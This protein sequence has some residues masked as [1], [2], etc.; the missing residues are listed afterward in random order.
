MALDLPS[1]SSADPT[2]EILVELK[3][4]GDN[5]QALDDH[6]ESLNKYTVKAQLDVEML[7][8]RSSN[9]NKHLQTMSQLSQSVDRVLQLVQRPAEQ[10]DTSSKYSA[11]EDAAQDRLIKLNQ[12]ILEKERRAAALD[13]DYKQMKERI[14]ERHSEFMQLQR[15]YHE[16]QAT[17]Q[18]QLKSTMGGV[19]VSSAALLDDAET[20]NASSK[21]QRITSMLREKYKLENGSRRVVSTDSV[22]NSV[23]ERPHSKKRYVF[24]SNSPNGLPV[25]PE[26]TASDED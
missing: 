1:G 7:L 5:Y 3:R 2:D 15:D 17:I 24:N 21:M 19:M 22:L 8:N 26:R 10:S 23:Q 13:A 12:E 11:Q 16:F 9:N 6:V 4:L 18:Q 20:P 14:Q 25:T